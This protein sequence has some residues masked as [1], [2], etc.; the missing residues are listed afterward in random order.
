MYSGF[1]YTFVKTT[2][3]PEYGNGKAHNKK[4]TVKGVYHAE[5][6]TMKRT[7][8]GR[9]VKLEFQ[10]PSKNRTITENKSEYLYDAKGNK[11][12]K[13]VNTTSGGVPYRGKIYK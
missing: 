4:N 11:Y 5:P 1:N 6:D 10:D 8:T 12:P 9:D 2:V 13:S 7:G 3:M